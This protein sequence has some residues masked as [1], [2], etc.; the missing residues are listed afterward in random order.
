MKIVISPAKSLNFESPLPCTLYTEHSFIKDS[1]KV[2]KVVKHIKP[3]ELAELM[4]I[5]PKLAELN[6]H[7]NQSWKTPFTPENARPAI[8]AFDGDVY[9]GLDA[10]TITPDKLDELQGKLRIL[11]GLYGLLKPLDLIQPYRLEM[12]TKLPIG[13]SKNLYEFWK[14]TLTSSLNKELHKNELFINLA[15]NEYFSAIDTK[16][17]KVPVITPEFKDYKDGHLKMI[18]FFAKKARG[19]MVRYILDSGAETIEDLKGFNYEGYNFDPKISKDKH[20]VFVR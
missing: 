10:Y 6:W 17:L 5:S 3:A 2:I 1:K 15:S 19:M 11:S 14:H 12:G 13:D 18:S 20:L 9:T 16:N 4:D 8:Y 7:R